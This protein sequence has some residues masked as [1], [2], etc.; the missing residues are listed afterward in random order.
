MGIPGALQVKKLSLTLRWWG[1]HR[2]GET[3][4]VIL[5]PVL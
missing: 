4:I 1:L 5:S 3:C 2:D